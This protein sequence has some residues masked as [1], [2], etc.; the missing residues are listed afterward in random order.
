M[1]RATGLLLLVLAGLLLGS[2]RA[3]ADTTVQVVSTDPAGDVVTLGTHQNFYLHLEYQS[4]QPV[5]VWARP[6]YRGKVVQAGSN[7]SR[8]YPTGSGEALG[9]FFLFDPDSWRT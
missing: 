9:W 6:Y 7:P 2:G 1:L 8:V 3:R 5:Q 4:D